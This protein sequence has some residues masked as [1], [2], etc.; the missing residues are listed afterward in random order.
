M[1]DI[2]RVDDPIRGTVNFYSADGKLLEIIN[3]EKLM[4]D[5]YLLQHTVIRLQCGEDE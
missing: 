2:I 5:P 4:A 1:K 3:Q